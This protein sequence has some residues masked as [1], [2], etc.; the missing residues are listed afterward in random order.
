MTPHVPSDIPAAHPGGQSIPPGFQPVSPDDTMQ[1]LSP[2]HFPA[3]AQTTAAP[4][5]VDPNAPIERSA[6][7]RMFFG[8]VS[9]A[10]M[11]GVIVLVLVPF[12]VSDMNYDDTTA[13]IIGC[14]ACGA[15]LTFAIRK[16]APLRKRGIA[17]NIIYPTLVTLGL[18]GAGAITTGM[19]RH[20]PEYVDEARVMSVVGL[21]ASAVFLFVGFFPPRLGRGVARP[22]L[23]GGE[24]P[25]SAQGAVAVANHEPALAEAGR[26]E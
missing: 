7:T 12:I 21:C 19:I 14:I 15:A 22:F 5:P 13:T 18:F 20:W 9:F 2:R 4:L 6:I 25:P 11:T 10:L 16:T 3:S 8:L 1:Q 26:V 23:V 17:R 24:K